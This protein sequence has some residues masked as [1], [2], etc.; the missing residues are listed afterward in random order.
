MIVTVNSQ[1]TAEDLLP[2]KQYFTP[3]HMGEYSANI[4]YEKSRR[5]SDRIVH[6]MYADLAIWVIYQYNK[7][8]TDKIKV[9]RDGLLEILKMN[10]DQ[11]LS[12]TDLTDEQLL[13]IVFESFG[14]KF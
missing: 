7:S 13:K 3:Y 14:P 6:R 5:P 2:L 12:V 1:M 4:S 8:H 11:E 9:N 10:T